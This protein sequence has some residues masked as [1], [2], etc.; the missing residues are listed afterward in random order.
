MVLDEYFEW[1]VLISLREQVERRERALRAL[2]D[3]GLSDQ[4][5]IFDAVKG[6]NEK[7]PAWWPNGA[8][9]WGCYRSHVAV[10]RE[11][12]AA[13]REVLQ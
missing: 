2:R 4:V 13:V 12:Q 8:G 6:A 1:V 11:A 5:K 7:R 9:A 3:G 10:L